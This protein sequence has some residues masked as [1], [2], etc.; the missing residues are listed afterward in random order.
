MPLHLTQT[1]R[2]DIDGDLIVA[3]QALESAARLPGI[4]PWL[5]TELLL[6]IG[7]WQGREADMAR[8]APLR[9]HDG[10]RFP[11]RW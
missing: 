10:E 6:L 5:K 8:N 9:S 2:R 7:R 4:P 1:I 3:Q 11:G